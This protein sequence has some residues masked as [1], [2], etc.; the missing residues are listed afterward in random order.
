M[1]FNNKI[2][3]VIAEEPSASERTGFIPCYPSALDENL[4]KNLQQ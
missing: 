4:K 2:I 3:G 1:N